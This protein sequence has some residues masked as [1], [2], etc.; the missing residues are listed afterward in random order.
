MLDS[1]DEWF[2]EP[3]SKVIT[4]WMPD[5]ANP[6]AR[7]SVGHIA[8]G[9]DVSDTRHVIVQGLAVRGTTVGISLFRATYVTVSGVRVED[10][11]G[12]GI[13]V[14]STTYCRI[15]DSTIARTGLDA[16][17]G[18]GVGGVHA[19]FLTVQGNTISDSGV[20]VVGD[21]IV[22]L[23]VYS[24]AAIQTGANAVISRNT[25]R[26]T[27]Y[28]GIRTYGEDASISQN[29]IGEACLVL[30]DCGAIYTSWTSNR[31][32]VTGNLIEGVRGD[33]SG[34]PYLGT[35]AVGIYIDEH[36]QQ[37]TATGNTVRD[38]DY[39][40]QIHN[41]SGNTVSGNTLFGNR[42]LQLWMQEQ[43]RSVRAD[44]DIH[45]N[46]V[47]NNTFVPTTGGP[48]VLH[49]SYFASTWDFAAYT[50]NTY[51]A[52]L[53]P[54]VISEIWAS[55]N[56]SFTFAEWRA[57]TVNGTPRTSDAN[58]REVTS[59]G[60]AAFRSLGGNIIP[61]GAITNAN[62]GW[63]TWNKTAPFGQLYV[64]TCTV[65][66]CLRY[67]AGST[68]SLMSSPSFS[69]TKDQWYRVSFDARVGVT[70]QG[71]SVLVREGGGG[72]AGYESV[73]G[74]SSTFNGTT[75]WTR[76]NFIFKATRSVSVDDPSTGSLG[77]RVDFERIQASQTLAVANLEMVPLSPVEV[78]LRIEMV[79]NPSPVAV[80]DVDCPVRA[81]QPTLCSQFV[82]LNDSAPVTWPYRLSPLGREVLFTRDQSLLDTDRDGIPNS[83]D[84]CQSTPANAGV[85]ANGCAIGEPAQ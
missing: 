29:Y 49:E 47:S 43:S 75:A 77:A 25:I 12:V 21:S 74:P 81:T 71:I 35:R 73:M 1:S 63:S 18:T 20:L 64:E 2:Y 33:F 62:I 55:G 5:G 24:V 68:V 72:S 34:T 76:Y 28:H 59:S 9:I 7:V 14:K 32:S 13:N 82:R 45:L 61:N 58:G 30:D 11:D 42:R 79:T 84:L 17:E 50:G 36:G 67:V 10:T 31:S 54:R 65:G 6:G 40:I 38:A 80:L 83:Q 60:Y 48:S 27:T 70:G 41:A 85:K 22:S 37:I 4:A 26:R 19:T 69:V 15:E 66:P 23:P 57:A 3:G 39:G 56:A 52:L 8:T 16:I 53:S 51:S 78:G 46:V 44:G